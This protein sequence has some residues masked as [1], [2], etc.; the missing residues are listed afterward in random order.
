MLCLANK[1]KNDEKKEK[2][3]LFGRGANFKVESIKTSG[4]SRIYGKISVT[5]REL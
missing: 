2:E 1:V 4:K 3:I 5:L